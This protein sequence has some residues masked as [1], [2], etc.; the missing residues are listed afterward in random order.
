M[1]CLIFKHGQAMLNRKSRLKGFKA[2]IWFTIWEN[3]NAAVYFWTSLRFKHCNSS[4]FSNNALWWSC[5]SFRCAQ[6]KI[7]LKNVKLHLNVL[8]VLLPSW[9]QLPWPWQF[10]AAEITDCQRCNILL[11]LNCEYCPTIQTNVIHI[12]SLASLL[13]TILRTLTAHTS[14]FA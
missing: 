10:H 5:L 7:V 6:A 13:V 11:R 4:L 9:G 8:V 1:A 3:L 14:I 12:K 2:H